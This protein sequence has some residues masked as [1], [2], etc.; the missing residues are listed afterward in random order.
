MR[1]VLKNSVRLQVILW[2]FLAILLSWVASSA[3]SYLLVRHQVL[4]FRQEMLAHPELYPVPIPEPRFRFDDLLLGPQGILQRGFFAH[5]PSR[6]APRGAR[7]SSGE[8]P[9]PPRARHQPRPTPPESPLIGWILVLLRPGIALAFAL[10]TGII[11]GRRFTRPL[12]EVAKGARALQEGQYDYRLPVQ[13]TDEFTEVSRVMNDMA[14]QV[15][16]HIARVEDDAKRRQQLL[17]DVAHELR[18]P[19]M[20]L[21]TMSDALESG[22]ADD[23]ARKE[24]AVGSLVRTSHRLLHLVTDLLQLAKLDLHELPIHRQHVE[25]REIIRACLHTHAAAATQADV[26]LTSALPKAPVSAYLDP[27]RLTQVL[28]NLLDNA[29]N[30]AKGAEVRVSLEEGASIRLVVAD[31]GPGI[32]AQHLPFLFD[33]FY[34]V[35]TARSP[36]DGH[37]GLGLRIARGVIEAH[38]GTLELMSEEGR[39]TTVTITLPQVSAKQ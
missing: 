23:P 10:G 6:P 26:T 34:R 16:Q 35:D 8:R 29:I 1:F 17:A 19:V 24:H 31:T 25:L 4:A 13:G 11:L 3:V 32:P 37:S 38:G 27:D 2:V 28:D 5:R 30:Y 12:L 36:A 22:V 18:G 14:Q 9:D 15:S 7:D 33:P 21:C 39:G 20:T